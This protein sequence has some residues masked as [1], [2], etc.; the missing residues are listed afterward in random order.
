MVRKNSHCEN[1]ETV[2]TGLKDKKR[3]EHTLEKKMGGKEER[4]RNMMREK[5]F[6]QRISMKKQREG[7][8]KERWQEGEKQNQGNPWTPTS[9]FITL[10]D[11]N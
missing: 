10:S 4:K 2:N 6:Y 11:L 1:R 3:V 9:F 8:K 7:R 5:S